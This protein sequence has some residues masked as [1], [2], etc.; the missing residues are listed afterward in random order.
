[1]NQNLSETYFLIFHNKLFRNEK[2]KNCENELV[3]YKDF[4][5]AMKEKENIIIQLNSDIENYKKE[6]EQNK[7]KITYFLLIF[8]K[9]EKMKKILTN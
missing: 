7:Q 1:L 5:P 2:L 3:K 4:E 9:K 8:I 6:I